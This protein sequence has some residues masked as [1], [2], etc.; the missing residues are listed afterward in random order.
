MWVISPGAERC[1]VSPLR[2]SV[3]AYPGCFAS[4]VFGIPDL[5]TMA[6][7]VVAA[8]GRRR[9]A[10]DVRVVSP[11]R[12][13]RASGGSR[14]DVTPLQEA[15]LLVVPGFELASGPDLEQTLRPL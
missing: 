6:G 11:R 13:V 12:V 8:A 5:L 2:I 7:H 10:Y 9:P 4:E 15:D 1:R 3:L 14:L